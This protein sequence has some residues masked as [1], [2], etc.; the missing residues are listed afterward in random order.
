MAAVARTKVNAEA[1]SRRLLAH[2][3]FTPGQPGWLDRVDREIEIVK[4]DSWKGYTIGDNTHKDL[5][6]YPWR[7]D[8]EKVVYPFYE[9]ILK[10]GHNIVCVHKGLF[11]P[12][13]ARQFANLLPYC[14]VADVGKAAKDWPQ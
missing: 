10:A 4:P 3:I 12:S 13:L 1:G 6:K 14:D 11:P 2:A 9:K 5:S 7:L 8:D